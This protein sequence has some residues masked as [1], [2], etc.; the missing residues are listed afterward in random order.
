MSEL[1]ADGLDISKP[2]FSKRI[3]LVTIAVVVI[4]QFTKLLVKG[5][6]ALG[7]SGM[8]LHSSKPLIDDIL[9]ITYVE[10]PGIAFGINIPAMK[11]FFSIFSLV[12]AIAIFLY[13][14]RNGAKLG[15]WERLALVLI[16]GGALG[17]L[18][19]RCFYGVI[20]G[21]ERLFYGHVVDFLDFGYKE[22]WWPVFN[23]ADSA[24]TIG[25]SILT[26][27]LLRKKPAVVDTP[28]E[29]AA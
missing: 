8:P 12:A 6:P 5:A 25:V 19:D 17:N 16:M 11:V 13:L 27:T 26:L 10:N 14:Q 3:Y 2:G 15:I 22:N 4:D 21:E 20:F 1:A 9:R 23:I 7:F 24:V 28:Q 18:I 29:A